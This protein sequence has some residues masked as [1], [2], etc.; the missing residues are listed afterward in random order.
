MTQLR[1]ALRAYLYEGHGPDE[2]LDRL[3]RLMD[4]LLDQRVATA[5]V[6]VLEPATG[7]VR[8]ASAG[9]PQPLLARGA[10][11]AEVAV[12]SRPLLGVGWGTSTAA[13][14]VLE[15]GD[16]LL[17]YTDGLIEQRGVDL[18]E[19]MTALTDLVATSHPGPDLDGWLDGLLAIQGP[20]PDDDT[21]LLAV[22]LA[23]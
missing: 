9:H 12:T 5:V 1:T 3:D 16:T 20:E 18:A 6:A 11:A 23:R 17:V 19:R 2:C 15:P 13:E 21:T 14:L 7:R 8:I 10:G 4:G 22:R